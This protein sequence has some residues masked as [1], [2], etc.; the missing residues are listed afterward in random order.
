MEYKIFR[1]NLFF[2]YDFLID[3]GRHKSR[4]DNSVRAAKILPS[5]S[6]VWE[7]CFGSPPFPP[8]PRPPER[9]CCLCMY[10]CMELK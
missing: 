7:F 9:G 2:K 1:K 5:F 6:D 4:K 8:T 3:Y 10:V